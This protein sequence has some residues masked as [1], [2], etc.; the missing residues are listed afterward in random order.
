MPGAA[1]E[2]CPR[3]GE[4]YWVGA[5]FCSRCGQQLDQCPGSS[6]VP[7]VGEPGASGGAPN[8]PIQPAAGQ[9][10]VPSGQNQPQMQRAWQSAPTESWARRY[11]WVL[12]I[13]GIFVVMAISISAAIAIP[14]VWGQQKKAQD[15]AAKSLVRNAM[16][17]LESAYTDDQ[18]FTTVT[19][20]TLRAI[21]PSISW[22][23]EFV[24]DAGSAPVHVR[25]SNSQV[26][27]SIDDANRY[28]VGTIS[29][30]GAKFGVVVDK[31]TGRTT[32]YYR[33]G[34]AVDAW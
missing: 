12:V 32:T 30:S 29:G 27:V 19:P 9:Q 31:S 14:T 11:W 34:R 28:E 22:P 2:T 33:D 15:S 17:V 6:P 23:T 8:W 16:T 10:Q 24:A 5:V 26:A 7:P 21:E 3:C 20:E 1:F 13:A 25:A 4:A 18:D